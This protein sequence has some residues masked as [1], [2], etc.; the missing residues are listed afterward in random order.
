MAHKIQIKSLDHS[1][2]GKSILAS[3]ELEC[4]TGEI[5]GIFGRNGTGKSTLFKILFGT[6]KPDAA[7]IYL[8]DNLFVPYNHQGVYIGYHTQE[9]FMPKDIV[10]KNIITMYVKPEKQNNVFYAQGIHDIRDKSVRELSLG[11]KRYLQLLLLLNLDHQ[12][13]V[14]D[15]PFA[16]VEPLYRNLIKKMLLEFKSQKG[17]LI[18]DHYYLDVLEIADRSCLIKEGKIILLSKSEELVELEYLSSKS[19]LL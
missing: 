3:A 15:E 11:Q 8:D 5:V 16:M 1:F 6:L 18:T 10:V 7:V 2:G 17:I 9:V 13:I 4:S 14:L 12:L 19:L